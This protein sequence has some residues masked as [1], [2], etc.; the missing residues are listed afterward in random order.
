MM[1]KLL[2]ALGLV[3][4]LAAGCGPEDNPFAADPDAGW[5][6]GSSLPR[7]QAWGTLSGGMGSHVLNDVDP[8]VDGLQ[9][10]IL[11]GFDDSMDPST[12]SASA[13]D[14][15]SVYPDTSGM[16]L[17]SV[18]YV[19]E[20][21]TAVLGGTFDWDHGY[22]LTVAANVPTDLAGNPLD[23][24]HNNLADGA[25]WDDA[26][27][28]FINGAAP[29]VD[30]TSPRVGTAIPYGGGL[31]DPMTWITIG[32]DDG[33]MDPLFMTE[34]YATL[35]RTADSSSVDLTIIS[36]SPTELVVQPSS[37]LEWGERY[38]VRASA[39]MR[40]ESGNSLDTDGNGYIW[41]DEQDF[42]WDFQMQDDSTTHKTPPAVA[43]VLLD[44]D[45]QWL[46][47][48]FHESLTGDFVVMDPA[49]LNAANIQLHD[50]EGIN[51]MVFEV[52]P[53]GNRVYC[54]FQRP[55]DFPSNLWVSA[56]VRD[57][58][59]NYFDGNNDG[60]GGTPGE[61]DYHLGF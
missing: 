60:L 16:T 26:R 17:T 41:P 43:G 53:A 37:A 35:V 44:T 20:T 25:P 30:L 56:M 54:Y 10:C 59:G 19:E 33:P 45:L 61:D 8:D 15:T 24:N 22:V 39:D 47:I 42:T 12:I 4:L 9:D 2:A 57:E 11:I 58:Y 48:E 34:A 14:I 7:I 36:V 38:T 3:A 21:R 29:A 32:F 49:T 5:Q 23:A 13:F 31:P 1:K 27:S 51:P 46:M 55:F 18:E 28:W 40:D 52:H 50:N 6:G